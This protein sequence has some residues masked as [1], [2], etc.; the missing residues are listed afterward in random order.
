[1]WQ[2]NDYWIKKYVNFP[3]SGTLYQRIQ[4]QIVDP[5]TYKVPRE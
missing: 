5:V 3:A 4:F 2:V 1:M